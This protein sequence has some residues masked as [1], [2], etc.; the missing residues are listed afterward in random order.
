MCIEH[1]RFLY[2][3]STEFSGRRMNT[4]NNLQFYAKAHKVVTGTRVV[5]GTA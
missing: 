3:M 4:V 1:T 2:N 5:T